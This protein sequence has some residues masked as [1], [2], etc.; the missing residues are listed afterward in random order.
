MRRA[1]R[2]PPQR[3]PI[4]AQALPR[5]VVLRWCAPTTILRRFMGA[6]DVSG[7]GYS[8]VSATPSTPPLAHVAIAEPK[9]ACDRVLAWVDQH[10]YKLYAAL[11]VFYLLGFNGQW[12]PEPD[13]ALYLTIG[14]NLALGAGY[15]YHGAPHRLVFPGLPW[16]F[17][18]LF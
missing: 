18:A 13:S 10:R 17:A 12:R 5:G 7:L 6:T 11:V 2:K 9:R 15:T 14:R 4:P 16:L 1:C 3:R 8:P